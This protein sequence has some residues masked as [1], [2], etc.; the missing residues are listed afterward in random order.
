MTQHHD[1]IE[2]GFC[3]PAYFEEGDSARLSKRLIRKASS[4]SI[5]PS[6]AEM[7]IRISKSVAHELGEFL[8][9]NIECLFLTDTDILLI[10]VFDDA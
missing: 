4:I 8:S 9:W 2:T 3:S 5:Q 1:F 6:F 7:H 10:G